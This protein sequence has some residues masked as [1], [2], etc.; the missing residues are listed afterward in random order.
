LKKPQKPQ[1]PQ[2]PRKPK[3]EK[4]AELYALDDEDLPADA[5]PILKNQQ[6]DK[7]LLQRFKSSHD[8]KFKE[9]YGGGR[10]FK[11]IC[12]KEENKIVM[13]KALQL[14]AVHWYHNVL[15]H[16]GETCT[17]LTIKQHFTWTNIHKDI[18]RT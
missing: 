6:K 11:L 1:K 5:F 14:S 13:L 4:L 12:N 17:E 10:L 9:F 3:L 2:K 7:K 15:C 16:L 8:L 18:F